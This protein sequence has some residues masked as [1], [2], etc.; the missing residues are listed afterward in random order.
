M[1]LQRIRALARKRKHR[2]PGWTSALLSEPL[3]QGS[4]EGVAGLSIQS[5]SRSY[6]TPLFLAERRLGLTLS[7]LVSPTD[8]ICSLV[9]SE[10]QTE[11]LGILRRPPGRGQR[12][13]GTCPWAQR[14]WQEADFPFSF[15]F[16][17][18][19]RA[20][21]LWSPQENLPA[22]PLA[23]PTSGN[24]TQHSPSY[25]SLTPEVDHAAEKRLLGTNPT[26]PH[27]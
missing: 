17:E 4:R 16:Q 6:L 15:H 3:T 2:S 5:H 8:P 9:N 21:S 24:V 11:G 13:G 27:P 7:P 12:E 23:Q 1:S 14:S 25:V 22:T 18:K 20:A 10:G 19:R 26:V